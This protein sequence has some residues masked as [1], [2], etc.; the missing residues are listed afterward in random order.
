MMPKLMP[1]CMIII[2]VLIAS[3]FAQ[4]PGDM[5]GHTYYDQQTNT[6]S[7]NRVA[8]C[9]DGS[10][11][12]CWVAMTSWPYPSGRRGVGYNWL[13]PSG[14]WLYP[15]EAAPIIDDGGY[16]QID[17]IYDNRGAF[18]YHDLIGPQPT[19]VTLAIEVLPGSGFFDFYD[20][21]DEIPT[22]DPEHPIYLLWPYLDVDRNDYIHLVMTGGP[23]YLTHIQVIGYTHS[24]DGGATWIDPEVVDTVTFP[25]SVIDA[26]PVS[27]RV[28]IAYSR[29]QD[30]TSLVKNDIYYVLSDNGL[31][32]DFQNGRVNIT[33]Y[34]DDPDSLWAGWDIDVIFDY[35][36]YFHIVWTEIYV[37]S[38]GGSLFH[39]D[40]KH[41]SEET[42]E[43]TTAVFSHVD[44]TWY[45]ICGTWNKPVCKM[46]L[47]VYQ[48]P[49]EAIFLTYTRFDTTDI[50]AGGYGNGE[51]Y[52]TYSEN[53]GSSW[54]DPI[55]L[56]NSH[57]PD[58]LPGDCDSDHWSSLADVV[59][60]YLHI[61]YINDKDAGGIPQ[62]EG[63]ATNNPVMYLAYPN[64]ILS[65]KENANR[66]AIF[67]LDQNRPN[68]FNAKTTISF[69][70]KKPADANLVIFDI[71]GAKVTTLVDKY[72]PAGP[73]EVVWDAKDMASG[74]YIYRLTA[75]G[76]SFSKK[77]VLL[78]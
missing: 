39:T 31:G 72:L 50:S 23:H 8:V 2:L 17:I 67:S 61:I 68:P 38:E 59:D 22:E 1:I 33:D 56:T 34:G 53:G 40:I 78:K 11:Y 36:D 41:Y 15:P 45:D 26:S 20:P 48:G 65:I 9:Y 64:P 75:D 24:T 12:V 52:M 5:V 25:G 44:S 51:I 37:T 74:T 27:D 43:I 21:P 42:G 73:H 76:S 6:S 62:T 28:V 32:W 46:N 54:T 71:T 10:A 4:S 60:D 14:E 69:E 7:G 55:D 30:T 77:A 18:A 66:P 3:A 49:P 57:T 35:D 13:S 58:C 47:G 19:N 29:S 63:V 70:L 16:P